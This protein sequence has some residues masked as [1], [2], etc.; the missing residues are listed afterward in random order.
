MSLKAGSTKSD[1]SPASATKGV[2]IPERKRENVARGNLS[3]H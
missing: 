1:I 3:F 2:E